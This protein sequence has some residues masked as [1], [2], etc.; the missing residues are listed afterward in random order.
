[1]NLILRDIDDVRT[2]LMRVWFEQH[3][4][5][6]HPDCPLRFDQMRENLPHRVLGIRESE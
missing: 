2:D 1:M 4:R 5:P 6:R 3:W